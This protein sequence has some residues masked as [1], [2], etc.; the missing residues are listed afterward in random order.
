M[1]ITDIRSSR[2]LLEYATRSQ[3]AHIQENW[4]DVS[5]ERLA[6]GAGFGSIARNAGAALSA[7]LKKGLND[8]H[9]Q[10]LDEIIGAL[11]PD[12]DGRGGLSSLA[13]RLSA[14]GRARA[15]SDTLVAHI[16]PSWAR[17]VLR[18]PAPDE[19][20]VLIQ[21]SA[22]LSAFM[23]ADK[24]DG[25]GK[26]IRRSG[27]RGVQSIMDR[28]GTELEALVRRLILI[29]VA[30]PSSRNYDAQILLGSLA[31]Y[32][33]DLTKEQLQ[34]SL[35]RSPLGFR[36][37][38]A[39]TKLVM[40]GG[41]G[42]HANALKPWVRQLVRD[43]EEMRKASLYPGRGLDLELAI[44]V[45]PSWSLPPDDWAGN[46]LLTRANNSEATIRE[47]GTATMGLWQR[48]LA[49]GRPVLEQ[50]E[51]ELRKLAAELRD[52]TSGAD[53]AG[54]RWVAA[55]LEHVI[56]HHEPVC[57]RWPQVEETWFGHVQEAASELDNHP[58]PPDL[59]PATK[60]LFRHM[61]LQNAGMYRRHAIETV[62]TSG[63]N[64][65][66]ARALAVLLDKEQD[67]HWLRSRAE[68]A[69]S[70]MQ[71]PDRPTENALTKACLQAFRNLKLDEIPED[72][73]PP[74][75]QAAE[76]H[77]ALFA[78]GDC[79]ASDSSRDR[80][81]SSREKLRAV[82]ITLASLEG[83]R[84]M[85]LSDAVRAAAYVLI[86]TSQPK[87]GR[88]M[89]LSQ[90]LLGKLRRHPDDVTARLSKW[91]LSFRFGPDGKI[92]PLLAAADAPLA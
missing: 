65:P 5:R 40:L 59:L 28:F 76:M 73:A 46:A 23:A 24:M 72:V 62:V 27:T 75:S 22:L 18:D 37:W 42:Q 49:E 64:E 39:V 68:F 31:S 8:G 91:A 86:F 13:M 33:F 69:L 82:L 36:V 57:N 51:T 52:T 53:A 2:Q 1:P 10:K 30:P 70:F 89:D 84:A 43:A 66:V 29:S 41:D 80:A 35:A 87:E 55:T 92:R 32:A 14:D 48:A 61:I 44:A 54:F 47:R 67:E 60:D 63:W 4:G 17:T 6:L 45:P 34:D 12:L 7:S 3:I 83:P 38:R 58:I 85:A 78:I 9:L 56:E 90:E 20:R 16:P 26:G 11:D 79:F 21:A 19:I 77:A 88:E 71:T 15:R 74:R 25:A 50:T 81:A